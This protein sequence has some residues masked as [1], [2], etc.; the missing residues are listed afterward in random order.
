MS[1]SAWGAKDSSGRGPLLTGA[2]R[3]VQRGGEAGQG[4]L[5]DHPRRQRHLR[6]RCPPLRPAPTR[7]R[8]TPPR[9]PIS[10]QA[11]S[12][13]A[14]RPP[15]RLGRAPPETRAPSPLPASRSIA[16][17]VSTLDGGRWT[18]PVAR[19]IE[20]P[21]TA[22]RG[23]AQATRA[24]PS[25]SGRTGC[26][27][28]P[29]R[30]TPRTSPPAPCAAP[31]DERRLAAYGPAP[32]HARPAAGKVRQIALSIEL[33]RGRHAAWWK[34]RP[35]RQDNIKRLVSDCYKNPTTFALASEVRPPPPPPA[36]ALAI[37]GP[38]VGRRGLWP[39]DPLAN[40]LTAPP[41]SGRSAR[42]VGGVR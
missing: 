14:R 40:W 38:S 34:R 20:S 30:A 29:L 32:A 41:P 26:A 10:P 15:S 3:R 18:G 35:P 22:P 27:R 8:R 16:G 9:E 17:P 4:P 23:R 7:P 12:T 5:R 31:P 36:L 6:H 19:G 21:L 33:K 1:P 25:S 42:W 11:C 2:A 37:P 13:S 24:R 28:R 39:P